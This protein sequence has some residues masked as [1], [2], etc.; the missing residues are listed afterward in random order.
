MMMTK[1]TRSQTM[2]GTK[3]IMNAQHRIRAIKNMFVLKMGLYC[4][5]DFSIHG[6]RLRVNVFGWA[7]AHASELLMMT[8]EWY[9]T[10]LGNRLWQLL[11]T[12]AHTA[13]SQ[14]AIF[15]IFFCTYFVHLIEYMREWDSDI[16]ES[17][18]ALFAYRFYFSER[19]IA[20]R[21][22]IGFVFNKVNSTCGPK[23][24]KSSINHIIFYCFICFT[25]LVKET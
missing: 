14:F 20:W 13:I 7:R 24:L 9:G 5:H 25:L 15:L 1:Q 11:Y 17:W 22:S 6:N 23:G 21:E 10:K 3:N 8:Q 16:D 4:W 12:H 18:S 19:P 2:S